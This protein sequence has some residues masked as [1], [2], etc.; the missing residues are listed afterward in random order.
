MISKR[1]FIMRN[2]DL[3]KKKVVPWMKK[4]A[5]GREYTFQQDSAPCHTAKIVLKW[6]KENVPHFWSPWFWPPNSP[7]CNPCDYW[8]WHRVVRVACKTHHNSLELLKKDIRKAF[9]SL[10]REEVAKEVSKFRHRIEAVV[11]ANGGHIEK[12]KKSKSKS[13]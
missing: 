10:K 2:L 1:T 7:D 3:L 9:R 12:R 13:K 11:K 5:R 8:L 4:I 6:L